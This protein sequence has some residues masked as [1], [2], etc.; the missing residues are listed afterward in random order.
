M[1]VG[2]YA[3][4][5]RIIL[6]IIE[7][8]K[9][10]F[11]IG[12][13]Q[14]FIALILNVIYIIVLEEKAIGVL[15]S[16]FLTNLIMLPIYLYIQFKYSKLTIDLQI[17]KNIL[18]FSLPL[19]PAALSGWIMNE[20]NRI[21]I[22]QYFTQSEVGIFSLGYRITFVFI[23]FVTSIRLAY[24]PLYFR[25]ANSEDQAE[26]HRR[27]FIYNNYFFIIS[28]LGSFL[29][30]FFSRELIGLFLNKNYFNAWIILAM[31]TYA[32]LFLESSS[33]FRMA[34]YQKKVTVLITIIVIVIATI[35]LLLNWLLISK[36]SIVG[37]G[38]ATIICS[39]LLFFSFYLASK[40]RGYYIQVK[41]LLL[42]VLL[43]MSIITN[44]I[45]WMIPVSLLTSLLFKIIFISVVLSFVYVKYQ[46][47]IKNYVI[48]LLKK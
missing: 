43:L 28:I 15:K 34:L 10:Y 25:L 31:L 33:I 1:Y 13:L 9:T 32:N 27:I 44:F 18:K 11:F 24:N 20:S 16:I 42:G 21:F 8:G 35:N 47:E 12:L 26:A 7:K 41:W 46:S 48:E 3:I 45:F 4:V 6:V 19:L 30:S 38:T 29:L 14:L 2:V 37:A 40:K 39:M 5:P 22:D 23:V 17:I 36:W